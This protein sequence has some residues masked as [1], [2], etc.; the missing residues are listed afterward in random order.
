VIDYTP[1]LHV[2]EHDYEAAVASVPKLDNNDFDRRTTLAAKTAI[3][4]LEGTGAN[5]ESEE[6]RD[7]LEI[8]LRERPDDSLAMTQLSWVYLALGRNAD[9][10]RLAEQAADSLPIEKDIMAG[11]AF[12]AGVAEIEARSGQASAAVAGLRKLLAL[13]AGSE[14][15]LKR[16]QLDP[17]WDPIRDDPAFQELLTM[18]EHVGP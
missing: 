8:R 18:K 16:L 13:P 15:S 3:R 2:V 14:I 10:L 9:A 6:A 5:P 17:V 4:A 7:L 1:Y 11:P 12:A